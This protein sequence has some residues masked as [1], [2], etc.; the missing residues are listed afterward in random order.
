ME[1]DVP[2]TMA[3]RKRPRPDVSWAEAILK[4]L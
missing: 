1:I 4:D 3:T 2:D